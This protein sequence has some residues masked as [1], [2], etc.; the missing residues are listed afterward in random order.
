MA[1]PIMVATPELIQFMEAL[2]CRPPRCHACEGVM[3]AGDEL[4]HGVDG[5]LV[6]L[7]CA[8]KPLRIVVEPELK[9]KVSEELK[10]L[11]AMQNPKRVLDD[12]WQAEV[13]TPGCSVTPDMARELGLL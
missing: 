4:G 10:K 2:G 8:A 5:T 11:A 9:A 1:K 7:H 12:G 3:D 13:R 6:H